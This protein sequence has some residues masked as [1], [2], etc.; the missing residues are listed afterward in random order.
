MLI[1]TSSALDAAERSS[2]LELAAGVLPKDAL[3]RKR[4]L[5]ALEEAVRSAGHAP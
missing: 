3:S 5:A 1:V 4:A 2:L